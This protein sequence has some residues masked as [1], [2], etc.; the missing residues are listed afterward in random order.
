MNAVKALPAV[1]VSS[2]LLFG[3]SADEPNGMVVSESGVPARVNDAGTGQVRMMLTKDALPD[4]PMYAGT[5]QLQ[6]DA[7]LPE[8]SHESSA[9]LVYILSG[10]GKLVLNGAEQTVQAGDLIFIPPGVLHSFHNSGGEV[11]NVFQVYS[12]PGPEERFKTWRTM[13]EDE[14]E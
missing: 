12:P 10:S 14:A 11:V 4:T 1:L 3:M 7:G 5:A 2:L 13:S 9:E 8:H 6:P